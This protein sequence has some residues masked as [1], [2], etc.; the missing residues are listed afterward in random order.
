[1]P[2]PK[3]RDDGDGSAYQVADGRWRAEVTIGWETLPGGKRK[4]V[5]RYVYGATEKQAKAARQ[6]LLARREA[7]D[8]PVGDQVT[9]AAWMRY[10]LDEICPARGC[11][12]KTMESYRTLTT[13]WIIPVIG[14]TRLRALAPEHVEQLHAAMR[15]GREWT[16]T[17]KTG[18]TRTIPKRPL[19]AATR[20]QAHRILS[21]A[22]KVAQQR[23]KTTRNVAALVDAPT[24]DTYRAEQYLTPDEARAFLAHIHGRWNEARWSVGLALAPRQGETLG[25]LW[26]EDVDLDT[27]RVTFRRQ[28]QRRRGG[29]LEL[30]PWTK[31]KKPR[32]IAIPKPLLA[33]LRAHRTA[34][35][36]R[37]LAIGEEWV[38]SGLGDLVF[39]TPYGRAVEPRADWQNW[40]DILAELGI[41][42]I[43]QHAAR[44]TA[45][46]LMLV[47]GVDVKVAAE[48]AGHAS[49]QITQTLYQHVIPAMNSAATD[50]VA[51][52]LWPAQA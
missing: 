46:T 1:M 37:R 13:N 52:A 6:Q 45:I 29:G 27:G 42:H 20:L 5:R 25:L 19:A 40:T 39:T 33:E 43:R 12:P 30:V 34:Q 18:K 2:A 32:T 7:G 9:V 41:D 51:A 8:L 47:Q 48:I 16:V 11:T 4:R 3:K 24:S 28:L 14:S 31:G 21:R 44:H 10:W 36:A 17:T 35:L 38:G 26:D 50:A 23:G 15:D 22:L 49:T